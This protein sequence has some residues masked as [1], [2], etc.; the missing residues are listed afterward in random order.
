MQAD[1]QTVGARE[2][3]DNQARTYHQPRPRINSK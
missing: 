2:L 3:G 1:L